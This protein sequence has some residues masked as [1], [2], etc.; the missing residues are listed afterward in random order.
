MKYVDEKDRKALRGVRLL[1]DDPF[2]FSCHP[3]V[4]CFNR[5]CRNLNLFLYPYDVIRLKARL[6][7][8]SDV[9]L[10]RYV[11]VVLRDGNFFPEVLLTMADNKER[12]CPFLSDAGCTVYEDR[13]DTCRKYPLE[14]GLIHD[15]ETGEDQPVFFFRPAEFCRGSLETGEWTPSTYTKDQNAVLYSKMTVEWAKIRRL[16]TVDPWG[17]EGPSGP[18]AKMAFMAC[19]N[20]DAFRTFVL[21]SSFKKRFKVKPDLLRK[22]KKD[23]TALLRLGFAWVRLFLFNIS[24]PSIRPR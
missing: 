16:F 15:A 17:P 13:P 5:C 18:K 8:A 7:I 10:D 21:E 24:S 3:E 12:T 1:P 11:D 4:S 19:Y 22:A 20:P 2:T 6:N 9:F 14:M 23:D